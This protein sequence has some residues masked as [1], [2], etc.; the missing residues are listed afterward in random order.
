MKIISISDRKMYLNKYAIFIMYTYLPKKEK[1][2]K[3]TMV[4]DVKQ[5]ISKIKNTIV[6][7]CINNIITVNKI[8]I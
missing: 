8:Y 6:T 5:H 7:P 3:E 1:R 2:Q 4:M